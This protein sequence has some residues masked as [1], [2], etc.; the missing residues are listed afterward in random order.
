MNRNVSNKIVKF[1]FISI[2]KKPNYSSHRAYRLNFVKGYSCYF[3]Q[4]RLLTPRQLLSM[5]SSTCKN[6]AQYM[7]ISLSLIGNYL[8]VLRRAKAQPWF[9]NTAEGESFCWLSMIHFSFGPLGFCVK[10]GILIFHCVPCYR[11]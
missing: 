1:C 7:G 10:L 2:K 8:K 4:P 9:F 6:Q 5:T 11:L 3:P